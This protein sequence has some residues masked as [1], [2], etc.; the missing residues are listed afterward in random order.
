[1][2]GPLE[3]GWEPLKEIADE[4]YAIQE[5]NARKR[6]ESIAK[7]IDKLNKQIAAQEFHIAKMKSSDRQLRQSTLDAA[8]ATLGELYQ[9]LMAITQKME[10]LQSFAK[11]HSFQLTNLENQVIKIERRVSD[12]DL[13]LNDL[14]NKLILGGKRRS[15]KKNK[16]KKQLKKSSK[17]RRISS[18]NKKRVTH[19]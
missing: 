17:K 3:T 4:L 8:K 18:K 6:Y 14:M 13:D 7:S 19:K 15:Y 1:M 12:A 5:V 16:S 2:S 10:E 9:E 11:A